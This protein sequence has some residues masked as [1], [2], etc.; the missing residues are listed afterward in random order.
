MYL[1]FRI[2]ERLVQQRIRHRRKLVGQRRRSRRQRLERPAEYGNGRSVIQRQSQCP[3]G[4]DNGH[5]PS[6]V[7][8]T[9]AKDDAV[10]APRS[11]EGL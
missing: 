6:D 3:V 9:T 1:S 2:Q 11:T 10:P 5:R 4:T 8:Q 7:P